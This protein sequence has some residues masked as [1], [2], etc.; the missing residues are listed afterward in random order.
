[1]FSNFNSVHTPRLKNGFPSGHEFVCHI[2]VCCNLLKCSWSFWGQVYLLSF[3]VSSEGKILYAAQPPAV[4]CP[5][6]TEHGSRVPLPTEVPPTA[7]KNDQACHT[8]TCNLHSV[9]QVQEEAVSRLASSLNYPTIFWRQ[10]SFALRN[11][12][13]LWSTCRN[14]LCC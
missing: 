4:F 9:D 5:R 7:L 14:G 12:Y 6:T 13:W 11:P 2:E 1:M 10:I 8:T 3:S